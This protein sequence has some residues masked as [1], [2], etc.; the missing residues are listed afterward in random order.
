MRIVKQ[1][2][3]ENTKTKTF[4]SVRKISFVKSLILKNKK[5]IENLNEE[6]SK[7]FMEEEENKSNA[8]KKLYF[9]NKF[10]QSSRKIEELAKINELLILLKESNNLRLGINKLNEIIDEINLKG[11]NLPKFDKD[12][13]QLNLLINETDKPSFNKK[14]DGNI[15]I[16]LNFSL[17][18]E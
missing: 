15:S 12:Y 14:R 4:D 5:D 1:K 2:N 10:I 18:D 17:L 11:E 8:S 7:K 6:K 9:K 16:L 13:M 3:Q